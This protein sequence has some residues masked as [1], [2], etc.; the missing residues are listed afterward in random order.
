MDL[1]ILQAFDFLDMLRD[2]QF[3]ASLVVAFCFVLLSILFLPCSPLVYVS[4][5]IFGP[6]IGGALCSI[7]ST[8]S[9]SITYLIGSKT[10]R[11]IP[12][13]YRNKKQSLELLINS[14]WPSVLVF[15]A[16]PI[17]PG[18][19][20]GYV[21]GLAKANATNILRKIFFV[22]TVKILIESFLSHGL[23]Q[24]ISDYNGFWAAL[25]FFAATTYF[26]LFVFLRRK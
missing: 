15:F 2:N 1:L 26:C 4:A 24:S 18:S 17:L 25:F 7:L 10:E 12:N 6:L 23:F 5:I 16:N 13:R 21:F 3:A 14:S 8:L 22:N 11:L 9:F 20:M 19:S